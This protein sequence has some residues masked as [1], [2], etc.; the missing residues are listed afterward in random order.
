MFVLGPVQKLC[1]QQWGRGWRVFAKLLRYG[2]DLSWVGGS[3]PKCYENW[4]RSICSSFL[5]H[6]YGWLML[7]KSGYD[8]ATFFKG[9]GVA[10]LSA[11]IWQRYSR[12]EGSTLFFGYI[13]FGQ[14]LMVL[15]V[16]LD[17]WQATSAKFCK[18]SAKIAQNFHKVSPKWQII[19]L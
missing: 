9:W 4:L 12:V 19:R 7:K 14:P 10:E 1:S 6:F 16:G 2:Y 11:T 17:M 18:K 5:S 3:L 13:V 8:M 15:E